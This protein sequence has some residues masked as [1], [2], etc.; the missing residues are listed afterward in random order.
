M[1][2]SIGILFLALCLVTSALAPARADQTAPTLQE[3]KNATYQGLED[4]EGPVTLKASDRDAGG[5][6]SPDRRPGRRRP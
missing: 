6:L 3:L 5:G 2:T 4:T 1:K